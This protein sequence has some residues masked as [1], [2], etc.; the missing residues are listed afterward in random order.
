MRREV[1]FCRERKF[2][3][4]TVIRDKSEINDALY[5]RALTDKHQKMAFSTLVCKILF[6]YFAPC[7]ENNGNWVCYSENSI[8]ILKCELLSY[9][10]I[11]HTLRA[12]NLPL[13]ISF[14][15]SY[16]DNYRVIPLVNALGAFH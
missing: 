6:L 10:N 11:L 15:M 12:Y 3:Y 4:I 16:P 8:F 1:Y 5:S 7:T 2:C 13:L 14:S 9:R